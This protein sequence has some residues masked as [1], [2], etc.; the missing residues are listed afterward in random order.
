VAVI[1][2]IKIKAI[3]RKNLSILEGFFLFPNP[4]IH[5]KTVKQENNNRTIN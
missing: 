4:T 1:I 3:E 2:T 5:K